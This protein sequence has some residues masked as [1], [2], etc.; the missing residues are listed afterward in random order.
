ML[1]VMFGLLLFTN[2]QNEEPNELIGFKNYT[3]TEIGNINIIITAA[4]GG[5]LKP[6]NIADRIDILGNIKGDYNSLQLA[7]VIRNELERLFMEND[8]IN[9]KPFL[10]FNNLHRYIYFNS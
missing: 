5:Y 10:V 1:L 6:D 9:A 7:N 4:H 2:N 8:G 3:A